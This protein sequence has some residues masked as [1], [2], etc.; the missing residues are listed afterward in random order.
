MSVS[1]GAHS[2]DHRGGVSR[3]ARWELLAS[4]LRGRRRDL[5]GLAV[6]IVIEGLPAYLSGRL[7]AL[8]TDQGFLAR[9]ALRG[10]AWLGVLGAAVV[11]GAWAN[12]KIYPRLGSIVEPFRDELVARTVAGTLRRSTSPGAAPDTAGVAR[13]TMQVELARQAYGGAL[14]AVQEF[15]VRIVAALLGLFSLAPVLLG[16]V[17]VPV[18]LG[19]GLFLGGLRTL[20]KRRRDC[21]MGDE[22]IAQRAT[23]MASGLRDVVACGG[24]DAV[25]ARLEGD[26]RARAAASE[27]L[28]GTTALRT[29][30]A[31]S[32]GL[33]PLVLILVA[34]PWLVRR[35][36]TAG[37]VLGALTYILQGI[38]PAVQTL[39]REF[40]GTGLG[41]MV[42]LD[43][44]AE[45]TAMEQPARA[46]GLPAAPAAGVGSGCGVTLSGVTFRY[47]SR[48]DPVIEDLDLNI[49]AD[50]HLVMVGP[51]GV[52]KST[53]AGLVAGVLQPQAGG[54]H[55]GGAALG[56]VDPGD[57][58][59]R[60]VLIPQEAYV[61]AGTLRENLCYLEPHGADGRLDEAV[62]ALA[63]GP[64]VER[65]GGYGADV[66]PS[67]LSAGERQLITLVRAYLSPAELV[68]LDEATCHLDPG[69]EARVEE[70]FARRPGALVIVAH[71]VS[72][73]LRAPRILVMDG[74]SVLTGTH[75]DLLG[76]SALYRDLVGHWMS[77]E[78]RR[79][80]EATPSPNGRQAAPMVQTSP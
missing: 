52:G 28:A 30:A 43:R 48:A 57:L 14:M 31:V 9:D 2:I 27:A 33:L 53:L 56:H 75:A 34:G 67:S 61:F 35:G 29:L 39:P 68:I 7:V 71:R 38:L 20:G 22:R 1:R 50:D 41:L 6:W 13:L 37:E 78:L 23:E 70:A 59:R 69:A 42:A 51:S 17:L 12:R 10:Y 18:V 15:A 79:A 4:S 5:A 45:A 26:V 76:R 62:A 24:E 21:L 80:G 36:A 55:M 16:M 47:G 44:I 40:A 46:A 58:V 25:A 74:L 60:R 19:V 73:A 77:P 72:S 63:A 64:L 49:E 65:L 8:A 3:Q 54:V 11:A 66:D 32:G